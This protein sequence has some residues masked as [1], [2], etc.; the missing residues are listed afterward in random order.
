M[1]FGFRVVSGMVDGLKGLQDGQAPA[2]TLPKAKK[3][4]AAPLVPVSVSRRGLEG[5]KSAFAA[6]RMEDRDAEMRMLRAA[7]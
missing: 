1:R 4:G 7:L 6:F 2:V 3:S 5:S